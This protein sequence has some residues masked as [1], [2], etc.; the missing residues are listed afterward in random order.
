[1]FSYAIFGLKKLIF[2]TDP[3]RAF[4]KLTSTRDSDEALNLPQV[5][6]QMY[7]GL[8]DTVEYSDG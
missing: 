8:L 4:Y 3:D 7:I 1:M 6:S 5:N 2:A